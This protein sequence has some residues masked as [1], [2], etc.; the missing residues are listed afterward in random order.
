MNGVYIVKLILKAI[1]KLIAAIV[2]T[3]V[4]LV[5]AVFIYLVAKEYSPEATEV[6]TPPD[7]SG[8]VEVGSTVTL[9]SF[10]TGFASLGE[11]ADFFMDGGTMVRAGSALDVTNA[12]DGI[13]NT[14]Q[15]L[16]A[17]IYLLQE[18]DID[19]KRTY[20]INQAEY[21]ADRI[22]M[23]YAFS[24]NY[25]AKFV[26]YPVKDMIGKV[27]SGIATYTGFGVS[28]ASRVQLFVPFKWPVR[29]F[30]LKS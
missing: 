18:V 25:S 23:P 19:S 22:G 20:S 14:L 6:V 26:P 11:N 15:S 27:N 1:F 29:A 30:N 13:T 24:L 21:Y 10:N 2:L 8:T 9:V 16:D 5:V 17:D 12:M 4:I 7:G 28:S 3:T